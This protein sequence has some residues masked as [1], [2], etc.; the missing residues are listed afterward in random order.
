MLSV[1]CINFSTVVSETGAAEVGLAA[2]L[3]Q[4]YHAIPAAALSGRT[5]VPFISGPVQK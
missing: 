3:A 5:S 1:C 2:E 4:S